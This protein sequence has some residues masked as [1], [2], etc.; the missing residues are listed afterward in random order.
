MVLPFSLR[1]CIT[2]RIHMAC[3]VYVSVGDCALI[4]MDRAVLSVHTSWWCMLTWRGQS[5]V[6][7]IVVCARLDGLDVALLADSDLASKKKAEDVKI[8]IGC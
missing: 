7:H 5:T 8:A 6:L 3:R 1:P 2:G 4:G